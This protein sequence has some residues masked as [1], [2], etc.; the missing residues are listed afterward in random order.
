MLEL[1]LKQAQNGF[2]TN[3]LSWV[4]VGI[5]S[6]RVNSDRPTRIGSGRLKSGRI[7][8]CNVG[9][10]AMLCDIVN[11][12]FVTQQ[13]ASRIISLS[14]TILGIRVSWLS[15]TLIIIIPLSSAILWVRVSWL[16]RTPPK[17]HAKLKHIYY[18]DRLQ[19][20]GEQISGW[21]CNVSKLRQN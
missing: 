16:W 18:L 15:N 11:P 4:Q 9:R 5:E 6:S 12:C 19:C 2:W 20:K 21:L 8:G 17:Y 3:L 10:V 14:S 7:L 1:G 13:Y